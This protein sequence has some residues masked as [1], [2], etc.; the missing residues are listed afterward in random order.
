MS[1]TQ[2]ISANIVFTDYNTGNEISSAI[3]GQK[4][5]ITVPVKNVSSSGYIILLH[6]RLFEDGTLIEDNLIHSELYV[7]GGVTKEWYSEFY[8]PD[9][10]VLITAH[11]YVWPDYP[12]SSPD[13]TT[14][15]TLPLGAAVG[16]I[17]TDTKTGTIEP[18]LPGGWVL[19]DTKT[20]TIE[21]GAVGGWVKT[22]TKTAIIRPPGLPPCQTDADCP[23]GEVCVNGKCVE[24]PVPPPSEVPWGWIAAGAVGAGGV[25][26]LTGKEKPKKRT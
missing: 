26:L 18:G 5:G 15:V 3:E 13:Y 11:S 2:I 24:K 7:S 4:V 25:V 23:A 1:K 17:L 21:I 19:A 16:W 20:G 9:A 12:P 8:M 22:D 10:D 14:M 6:A